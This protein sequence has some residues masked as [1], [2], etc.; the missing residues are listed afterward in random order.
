MR[1]QFFVRV[2][3]L[4]SWSGS[5]GMLHKHVYLS[6]KKKMVTN[7][8]TVQHCIYGVGELDLGELNQEGWQDQNTIREILKELI[9]ILK[10]PFPITRLNLYSYVS[11]IFWLYALWICIFITCLYSF[12]HIHTSKIDS[13]FK[14]IFDFKNIRCLK[15]KSVTILIIFGDF[16]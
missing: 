7:F 3:L 2:K 14:T 16:I 1:S 13:T 8:L 10:T 9:K 12:T 4:V 11:Y 6:S 5:S 15:T